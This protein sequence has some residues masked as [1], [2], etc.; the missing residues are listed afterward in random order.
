MKR[1][2]LAMACSH[3][4]LGDLLILFILAILKLAHA[5]TN[6]QYCIRGDL[7]CATTANKISLLAAD[8]VLSIGVS[9]RSHWWSIHLPCNVLV[10][11]YRTLES[12]TPRLNQT[13]VLATQMPT[14]LET[15][16]TGNRSLVTFFFLVGVLFPGKV[17]S[18]DLL[19]CLQQKQSM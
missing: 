8:W 13:R 11:S 5:I 18:N 7:G 15:K 10:L 2:A 4:R 12:S 16:M 1:K 17:K 6:C 3:R 9:T 14:G 19:L